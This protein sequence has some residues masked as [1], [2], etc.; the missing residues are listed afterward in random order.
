MVVNILNTH[1]TLRA[2]PLLGFFRICSRRW[3]GRDLHRRKWRR[4]SPTT[5]GRRSRES[6]SCYW[7]RLAGRPSP[8][9]TTAVGDRT[10]CTGTEQFHQRRRFGREVR[11][12]TS[13]RCF[14]STVW[15]ICRSFHL[16]VFTIYGRYRNSEYSNIVIFTRFER[17]ILRLKI[18]LNFFS[19]LS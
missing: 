5:C 7:R 16:R 2:G 12:K 4:I 18:I 3:F 8:T 15:Y 14:A 17:L 19:I 6:S 10:R 13:A 1:S 9:T 11:R